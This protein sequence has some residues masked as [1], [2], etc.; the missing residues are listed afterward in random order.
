[1]KLSVSSW[2]PVCALGAIAAP[3]YGCGLEDPS[4]IA[5]RRSAVID[6][7]VIESIAG[8]KLS[9]DDALG[10]GVMR[11]YGPAVDVAAARN[12]LTDRARG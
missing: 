6:F 12:W 3:A 4:F 2:V 10:L 1:M 11:L 9:F 7:A 8:G 5:T